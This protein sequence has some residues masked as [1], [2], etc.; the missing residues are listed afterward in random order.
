MVKR[1]FKKDLWFKLILALTCIF[2]GV[3]IPYDLPIVVVG[4]NIFLYTFT[5]TALKSFT[6]AV[7]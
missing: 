1:L 5:P 4:V 2:T 3:S 7:F 6:L